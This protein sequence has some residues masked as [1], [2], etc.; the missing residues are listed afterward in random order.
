MTDFQQHVGPF[1]LHG[2]TVHTPITYRFHATDKRSGQPVTLHV[3]TPE[4]ARQPALVEHFLSV[5]SQAIRLRHPGLM[6]VVDAGE[7]Q[8]FV[9]IATQWVEG[10]SLAEHLQQG[11]RVVDLEAAAYILNALTAALDYA[12]QQGFIHG[13]I[14]LDQIFI[15]N[16]NE[17]LLDGFAQALHAGATA[18]TSKAE[19]A[20]N[21]PVAFISP[22]MAPEQAKA[23]EVIDFRADIY[24]LGAVLYTMLLGHPPFA[25]GTT[26]QLLQAIVEDPPI[27]PES[28]N[29]ALPPAMVYVLKLV[30]AKDPSVRYASAGEFANVFLQSTQW[31]AAPPVTERTVAYQRRGL[32]TLILLPLAAILCFAILTG[33]GLGWFGE[34]FAFLSATQGGGLI[35]QLRGLLGSDQ[36]LARLT[37]EPLML[38]P[39]VIVTATSSTPTAVAV[40]P[41]VAP[42]VVTT[43]APGVN[44]T[45]TA[46]ATPAAIA[47]ATITTTTLT[48]NTLITTTVLPADASVVTTTTR[49]TSITST[50]SATPVAPS[51]GITTTVT[52]SLFIDPVGLLAGPIAAGPVIINGAAEPGMAVQVQV[53]GNLI[54]STETKVSGTWSLIVDLKQPGTYDITVAALDESGNV[55]AVAQRAV[56]AVADETTPSV[57]ANTLAAITT[58]LAVTPTEPTP[59]L[60]TAILTPTVVAPTATHTPEP[61]ATNTNTVQP[62]ATNT[63]VPTATHTPAPT[64]TQTPSLTATN[65][66]ALPTTTATSTNTLEPTA[67]HTA[68]PTATATNTS[69]VQPTATPIL[70]PTDTPTPGMTVT[71]TPRPTVTATHTAV[72]TATA[73]VVRTATNTATPVPTAT[74]TATP[75][76]TATRTHTALPTMTNTAT[77]VPTVTNT[78]RPTATNTAQ[79]TAT[80]TNTVAPTATATNTRRPM[81]T[82]TPRPTATSTRRPTA[83]NTPRPTATNTPRPTATNTPRP[84]ATNTPRPTATNTPRPTATNTPLPPTN[85][86]LPTATN[87]PVP[88]TNTPRPTNTPTAT[89]TNTPAPTSTAVTG[90]IVPVAPGDGNSGQGQQTFSW[91]ANFTPSEG[92]AFELVFWKAGQ[93]PLRQ[94]FGMAAPTTNLN[95]TLDLP[96]LDEQLGGTFDTGEYNWGVLL[97]RTTPSYE[98][99]QYLGGGYRFTYYRGG[100]D[101]GSGGQSSGE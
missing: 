39:A 51:N 99:I 74:H 35:S 73:T 55:V 17:V 19:G 40:A 69:T 62:T 92:Y 80:P 27:P 4:A 14:T 21:N 13:H 100:G 68:I 18:S 70:L 8:G 5:G 88:P 23:D 25:S 83:T 75:V 87:T 91:T 30:L 61:T 11:N 49:I 20:A 32:A 77:A 2:Q 67:T 89:G 86:P 54:G 1:Q 50:D 22:F 52:P 6:A 72:P 95:V 3:L 47:I 56:T 53:N 59:A 38:T 65:T 58:T 43:V 78:P 46:T 57:E 66:P 28:I 94:S 37:A 48:P 41:T 90:S 101:S 79:P 33:A 96:R 85:T 97:V 76:P 29:P 64:V 24:S 63:P 16:N 7:A 81:A 98:R 82:N 42:T 9:Y 15:T 26:Q 84:T 36:V 71:N 44:K 93:D 31:R 12:H 10:Q 60:A 34:R 45:E